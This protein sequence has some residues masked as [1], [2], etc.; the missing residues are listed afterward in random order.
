MTIAAQ[1]GRVNSR[2][3]N[4]ARAHEFA[5]Y[6]VALLRSGGDPVI[7][8]RSAEA[9]GLPQRVKATLKAAVS[10][11]VTDLAGLTPYRILS[12]GFSATLT[13]AA[14]DAVLADARQVPLHVRFSVVTSDATAAVAGEGSAKR[15]SSI[16]IGSGAVTARKAA[17]HVVASEELL[18]YQSAVGLIETSLRAGV[19]D[20]VDSIFLLALIAGT[21]PVAASGTTAAAALHD[22]RVLLDAATVS[23][24]SRFHLIVSP[25]TCARLAVMTTVTV[26]GLAFPSLTVNGGTIGGIAVHASD[27]LTTQ[28]VLIDASQVVA[29]ADPV[30]IRVSQAASLQ[31]DSAPTQTIAPT[32]VATA[33]V[34]MFQTNS[35]AIV[36]ERRFGWSLLRATAAQ[37]LSGVAWAT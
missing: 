16:S 13:N 28:A 14:F 2:I 7:A 11:S 20:A 27:A 22:I 23:S 32:P 10:G 4:A 5:T 12:E 8:S 31:M 25:A 9:D 19:S 17:V 37:S 35:T 1:I 36:C 29:A 18:R 24:N 30:G 21:T 6:A 15:I 26:D 34:S 33:V 3:E